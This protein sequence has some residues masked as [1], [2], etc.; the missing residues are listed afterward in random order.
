MHSQC[1]PKTVLKTSSL[2]MYISWY[3]NQGSAAT[4]AADVQGAQGLSK[5]TLANGRVY[6]MYLK[7]LLLRLEVV[8]QNHY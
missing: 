1:L 8:S 6:A 7:V 4:A 3:K 5:R 2:N